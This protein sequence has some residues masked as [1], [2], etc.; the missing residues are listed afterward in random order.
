[1]KS[2]LGKFIAT[3]EVTKVNHGVL[4]TVDI[5]QSSRLKEMVMDGTDIKQELSVHLILGTSE[6]TYQDQDDWNYAPPFKYLNFRSCS[7]INCTCTP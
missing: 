4:L 3:A 6:C 5:P 7:F 2:L 1:M